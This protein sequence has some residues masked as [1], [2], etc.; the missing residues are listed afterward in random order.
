MPVSP[1]S[2]ISPVSDSV[3]VST[4]PG[5]LVLHSL[6]PADS[7]SGGLMT[8]CTGTQL[9]C[10]CAF[11]TVY[12]ELSLPICKYSK[13]TPSAGYGFLFSPWVYLAQCLQPAA[14]SLLTPGMELLLVASRQFPLTWA[15]T[16]AGPFPAWVPDLLHICSP[17]W[18]CFLARMPQTG[19]GS[20]WL[21]LFQ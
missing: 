14:F 13:F 5:V 19:V 6:G 3:I 2:G 1:R 16:G 7:F 18:V 12:R 8:L 15:F 4:R 20:H 11:M 10:L 9:L 17:C 21:S